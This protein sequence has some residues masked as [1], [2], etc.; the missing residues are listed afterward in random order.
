[1]TLLP[2][3]VTS[4]C[5][6]TVSAPA[7]TVLEAQHIALAAALGLTEIDVRRRLKVAIFSTGDEVVEPGSP[8]GGAAIYDANRYLLSALLERRGAVVTDLGI[9]AD[10]PKGLGRAIAA[11]AA[12][13]ALV[14]TSGGVSTGSNSPSNRAELTGDAARERLRGLD[15]AEVG[16]LSEDEIAALVPNAAAVTAADTVAHVVAEGG[17]ARAPRG[18]VGLF[19]LLCVINLLNYIDR[20]AITGFLDP[21]RRDFQINDAQLGYIGLAF[22]LT[23]AS[24]P[25]LF[26]WLGD[27][28]PRKSIIAAPAA[29]S[30]CAFATSSSGLNTSC[31]V[32]DDQPR[33]AIAFTIAC[34]R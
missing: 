21:I 14:L 29:S 22:L 18:D 13:H 32:P 5:M 23:Y 16:P 6:N 19:A 1:M 27:R 20:A 10:E 11:A 33:S 30:C 7:G 24:L 25:P 34:G 28:V 8:R 26:G 12:D 31:S 3:S 2:S 4:S 17:D 15:A 9:L